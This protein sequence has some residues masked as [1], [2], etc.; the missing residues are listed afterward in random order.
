MIGWVCKVSYG[1]MVVCGILWC[2]GCVVV[3]YDRMGAQGCLMV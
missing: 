2:D 1:K 3:S